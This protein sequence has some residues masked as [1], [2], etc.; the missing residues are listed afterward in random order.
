[1]RHCT[2]VALADLFGRRPMMDKGLGFRD[3]KVVPLH[4]HVTKCFVP[5]SFDSISETHKSKEGYL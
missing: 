3:K 1:M 2:K 5:Y 4:H